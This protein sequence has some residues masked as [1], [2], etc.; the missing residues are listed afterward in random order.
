MRSDVLLIT[1][2][3]G[4]NKVPADYA[5]FFVGQ[6][7]L[8]E[9]HRGWDPGA[10]ELAQEMASALDAPLFH[11]TTTRLL[12]DLNRSV[13]HRQL[14]SEV[15][16][17]LGLPERKKIIACH[18]LPHRAAV[19]SAIAERIA[20]GA[21]VIHI[22]SHSFTPVLDGQV[23]RADIA[24]LYDPARLAEQDFSARWRAALNELQPGLILRRNYPYR[25]KGDGLTSLL[26]KRYTQDR[27]VGIELEVNQ[28]FVMHGGLPWQQIKSSLIE[29]LRTVKR[30]RQA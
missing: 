30:H 3:H 5:S 1:C 19:E 14:H 17:P 18:Y 10:L 2:E 22:A 27:Y 20:S 7:A 13:G 25:G 11:A 29:S 9:S 15:K 23:R 21:R 28:R 16:R 6:E 12:V 24:W 4:G 26:R 8:L